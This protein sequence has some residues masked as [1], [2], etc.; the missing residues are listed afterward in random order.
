V[1]QA[2]AGSSPVAHLQVLLDIAVRLTALADW[3][4]EMNRSLRGLAIVTLCVVALG[5]GL[6]CGGDDG[7]EDEDQITGAIETA[8]TSSEPSV[9]T[10][11]QTQRFNEQNT[12]ETGNAALQSCRDSAGEDQAESV[13]VSNIEI[14]GDNATAD[15][16]VTGSFLDGSTIDVAL[17][18]ENAQWK[19]DELAGFVEFDREAYEAAFEEEV[20]SDEEIPP[21][22]ADC[23]VEGFKG[24]SDE[25][26]QEFLLSPGEGGGEELFSGCFEQ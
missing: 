2:V 14:D 1:V 18:K 19:L 13:D 21:R 22:A 26:A 23:I 6:G 24:F 20:R 15:V 12:G 9:C 11:L 16:A 3:R 5:P 8:A 25:E 7:N 17:V 4:R 10:E